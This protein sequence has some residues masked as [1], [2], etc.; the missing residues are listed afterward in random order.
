MKYRKIMCLEPV[1]GR[2][3][4]AS[5]ATTGE[6]LECGDMAQLLK[7]IAADPFAVWRWE[8]VIDITVEE[9]NTL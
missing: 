5:N 4:R 8:A 9:A 7:R 6:I 2:M 1:K 3:F